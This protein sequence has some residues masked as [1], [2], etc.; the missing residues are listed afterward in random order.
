MTHASVVTD[1]HEWYTTPVEMPSQEAPSDA[2][3]GTGAGGAEAHFV[4]VP[5]MFQ[6]HLIPSV[7]TALLLATHGAVASVV[8]TPYYAGRDHRTVDLTMMRWLSGSPVVRVVELPLDCAAVGLPDEAE[9]VDKIPPGL[10]E[11]YFRALALLREPLERHLRAG[12]APY[13]TCIVGDFCLPWTQE[14]AASLGVPRVSFFSMCAFCVLCQHNVERYNAYAGVADGGEPVVVPGLGEKRFEVTRAQ[15]PGFFGFPGWEDYADAVECAVAEADGVV[16]N[17]FLEMEPEFVA[18]YEAA[19]G[20]KVYT[21]VSVSLYHQ[22]TMTLAARGKTTAIDADKCL[23]WLDAKDPDSVV[24]VSF[25]ST[26]HADPKQAI[27]NEE[28]YGET[29][30][31]FLHELETR[32][33]GRGLL[34]RG[35]APQVLIL[36]HAATGGFVTH[37]GWNSMLE[38]VAAGLPVVT[39]SHFSDQFLNEKMAVEV[40]GIGVSVGFNEP[41]TFQAEKKDIVVGRVEVQKAVRSIMDGGEDGKE[42]RRKVRALADQARATVQEGGSWFT[43]LLDLIKSFTVKQGDCRHILLERF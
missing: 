42:R 18:G 7:D 29:V 35:W 36:S 31:E 34:V 9:D 19:R 10:W 37:C 5:L 17:T 40:L 13:P 43:N 11:N 20:M 2:R 26:V 38:A 28:L 23:Q 41:L 14:L 15:A 32:V 39:W 6:G 24:Y 3:G 30:R 4:F 33:A 25:G 1:D 16:M 8:V 27:K 22:R 12:G 21:I